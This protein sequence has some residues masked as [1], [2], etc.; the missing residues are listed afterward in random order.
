MLWEW[1]VSKRSTTSHQPQQVRKTSSFTIPCPVF[2]HPHFT[3]LL[4]KYKLTY[5]CNCWQIH[6]KHFLIVFLQQITRSALE[7]WSAPPIPMMG[8]VSWPWK[9]TT[10]SSGPWPSKT[11]PGTGLLAPPPTYLIC[12]HLIA[13]QAQG[14]LVCRSLSPLLLKMSCL[15][16][17]GTMTDLSFTVRGDIIMLRK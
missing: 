12:Q 10:P 2:P 17:S 16:D 9:R 14:P 1:H 5:V 6:S 15:G 4:P 3:C 11:D 8:L 13:Q 7:P